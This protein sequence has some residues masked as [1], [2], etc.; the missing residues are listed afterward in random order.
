MAHS[1][2]QDQSRS[3]AAQDVGCAENRRLV[4]FVENYRSFFGS[5]IRSLRLDVV[6]LS[7]IDSIRL[8][9]RDLC[10]I[11]SIR[12]ACASRSIVVRFVGR[13]NEPPQRQS[14]VKNTSIVGDAMCQL[15]SRISR[16]DR[17]KPLRMVVRNTVAVGNMIMAKSRPNKNSGLHIKPSSDAVSGLGTPCLY[18]SFRIFTQAL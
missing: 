14:A 2:V 18:P 12:S 3:S 17:G 7:R 11:V 10:E 13:R 4:Q 1:Q 6:M 8:R 15:E 5:R 9:K 16:T